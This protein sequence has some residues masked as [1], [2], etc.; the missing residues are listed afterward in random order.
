VDEDVVVWWLLEW[1]FQNV[2]PALVVQLLAVVIIAVAVGTALI[3]VGLLRYRRHPRV[4]RLMLRLR[5]EHASSG[6]EAEVIDLRLHLQEEMADARRAVEAARAAGEL[7]GDLPDLLTRLEMAA[8]RVDKY[9]RLLQRSADD[10]LAHRS[11]RPARR[12]VGDVVAAARDL[13]RAAIAALD[14][15][16]AG[17]L[18]VLTRAVEQEVSWVQSGVEA[19]DELLEPPT[20]RVPRHPSIEGRR[21]WTRRS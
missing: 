8:D 16:T 17:E 5:A 7:V 6:F 14:V 21:D 4:R 20:R 12:Q 10:R 19:I 3:A 9:L 18:Q 13:R 1:L 15:R 11:L 2:T